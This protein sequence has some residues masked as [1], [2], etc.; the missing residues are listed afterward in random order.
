MNWILFMPTMRCNLACSYC[1]FDFGN[2]SENSYTW[3]GYGFDHKIEK[4]I[5][6]DEVLRYLE[7]AQPYHLEI[8]GGE[9]ILWPGLR[10]LI[11]GIPEGN[12]W[13]ITSNT[14]NDIKNIDF[15]KCICWSA[16]WHETNYDKFIE[17]VK[18]IKIKFK[19]IFINMVFRRETLLENLK[20]MF[21]F[22]SQGIT[23]NIIPEVNPGVDWQDSAE[24]KMLSNMKK[25]GYR[26]IDDLGIPTQ[27]KTSGYLCKG[28]DTYFNIG[29]DGKLYT[30]YSETM[31]GE[32]FGSIYDSV[33]IKGDV[34]EC[35]KPCYFDC[36]ADHRAHVRK[37]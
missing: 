9:P 5:K 24:W 19:D 27:E 34:H 33:W 10:E 11:R 35:H 2:E 1:P 23:P 25:M 17:N 18:A 13:A 20:M 12:T 29:P 6:P 7:S 16:S 3:G 30:C 8:C 15:T 4:E 31:R 37:I 32:S 26:L 28:G 36:A 14:L 22:L 21:C